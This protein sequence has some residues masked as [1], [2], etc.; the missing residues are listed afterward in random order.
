VGPYTGAAARIQSRGRLQPPMKMRGRAT[1]KRQAL[2]SLPS[3]PT[4]LPTR[5]IR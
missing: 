4:E 5:S 3:M 1:W 2:M